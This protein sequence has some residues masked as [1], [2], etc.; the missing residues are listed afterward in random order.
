MNIDIELKNYRCFDANHPARLRLQPGFIGVVGINNSGKSTLL[1]AL[2]ELRYLISSVSNSLD[3]YLERGTRDPISLDNAPWHPLSMFRIDNE[4]PLSVMIHPSFDDPKAAMA[5]GIQIHLHRDLRIEVFPTRNGTVQPHYDRVRG[6]H[7]GY[8]D[9]NSSRN[10]DICRMLN[11]VSNCCYIGASRLVP[12][13]GCHHFDLVLGR[14]LVELWRKTKE[15]R[16]PLTA[17]RISKVQRALERIFGVAS[18]E[19]TPVADDRL[20]TIVVDGRPPLSLYEMGSGFGEIFVLLANLAGKQP[21]Y[22]LID[23]PETHLHPSLQSELLKQLLS[24]SQYGVVFS[25]HNFGLARSISEHVYA[26][27][28]HA[29]HS[30]L[31]H[32]DRHPSLASLLGE[33]SYSSYGYSQA[34]RVL[35]V[36]GVNDVLTTRE[37]LRLY[38]KHADTAIVPLGGSNMINGDRKSELD[39]LTKLSTKVYAI[40]DSERNSREDPLADRIRAFAEVAQQ[41]GVRVCVLERRAFENYLSDDA[42][43]KAFGEKYRA[44]APY[45]RATEL[46]CFWGKARSCEAASYMSKDELDGTDLGQF[47]ATI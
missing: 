30:V 1:R 43:R 35:L 36:E 3:T 23:E 24:L 13:P 32:I 17:S 7:T 44:A 25:T 15:D 4:H 9:G 18:I 45:Q 31:H 19:I 2:Y 42:V 6:S 22:I 38:R 28:R 39:I 37:F 27:E 8:P 5:M 46:P 47:L 40:I 16:N 26:M 34:A 20:F 10:D 14:N 41:L 12:G 21:S 11:T 33:L 29:D